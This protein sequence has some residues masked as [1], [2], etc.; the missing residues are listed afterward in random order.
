[1]ESHGIRS[2]AFAPE[3]PMR[4]VERDLFGEPKFLGISRDEKLPAVSLA[5][6]S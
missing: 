4:T 1:M 6:N 5:S 3:H 2:T